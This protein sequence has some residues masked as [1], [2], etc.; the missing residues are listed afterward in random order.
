MSGPHWQPK[1]HLI[2]VY[3]TYTLKDDLCITRFLP[4]AQIEMFLVR[5]H[6]LLSYSAE[7]KGRRPSRRKPKGE[8]E[9]C[10][11]RRSFPRIYSSFRH[12]QTGC[13]HCIYFYNSYAD[14]ILLSRLK[15]QLRRISKHN[16]TA[17][18]SHHRHAMQT[19]LYSSLRPSSPSNIA[20]RDAA[21]VP[22][23]QQGPTPCLTTKAL[24][25]LTVS[26]KANKRDTRSGDERC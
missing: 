11:C 8:H 5:C 9:A 23:Y 13:G 2:G 12:H 1:Y 20:Y 25:I 10:D 22:A 26:V 14:P 3:A 19:A 4:V 7:Y 21:H 15:A 18:M 17:A 24:S 16:D 6:A